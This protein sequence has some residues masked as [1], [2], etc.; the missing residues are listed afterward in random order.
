MKSY[1]SAYRLIRKVEHMGGRAWDSYKRCALFGW[2]DV[3][4]DPPQYDTRLFVSQGGWSG[5]WMTTKELLAAQNRWVKHS[6]ET[7]LPKAETDGGGY[8]CG[9]CRYFAALDSDYG[10]CCNT[11]SVNDGRVTFEHGGCDKPSML[12]EIPRE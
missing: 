7:A 10:I 2:M 8:Q 9:G 11:Q 1:K 12:E 5:R 3:E 6:Y 4:N